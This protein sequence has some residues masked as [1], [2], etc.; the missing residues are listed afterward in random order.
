METYLDTEKAT[1]KARGELDQ[2]SGRMRD[3][4]ARLGAI[5]AKQAGRRLPRAECRKLMQE[6]ARLVTEKMALQGELATKK[7]FIQGLH[8]KRDQQKMQSQPDGDGAISP[9]HQ[10]AAKA[11]RLILRKF[12]DGDAQFTVAEKRLL[13]ELQTVADLVADHKAMRARAEERRRLEAAQEKW[14]VG[15]DG[16]QR[17]RELA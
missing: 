14:L 2:L 9:L 16:K 10:L 11:Y 4:D 8:L 13:K 7:R 3:I 1:L 15:D 5:R 12:L 6:R 17:A